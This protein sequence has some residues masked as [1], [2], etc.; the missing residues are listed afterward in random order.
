MSVCMHVCMCILHTS[1]AIS[2]VFTCAE[3]DPCLVLG[4]SFPNAML[5]D[6]EGAYPNVGPVAFE[7]VVVTERYQG[8]HDVSNRVVPGVAQHLRC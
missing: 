5:V 3:V 4:P 2:V 1:E 6:A 8:L 7:P